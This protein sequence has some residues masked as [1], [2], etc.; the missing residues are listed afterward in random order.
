MKVLSPL[1]TRTGQIAIDAFICVIAL[2]LAYLLRLEGRVPPAAQ[3]QLMAVAPLI[4]V[5]RAAVHWASGI[6]RV[7]WRYVGIR[8]ALLFAR[9]VALVSIVLLAL[10]LFLPDHRGLWQV[11]ISII[12]LEGM[13]TFLGMAGTRVLRRIVHER[14][15]KPTT[16]RDSMV[17]TVLV[18]AGENALL[19]AK[20]AQRHPSLGI[21]VVGYVDDDP[22]KH[23]MEIHGPRVLGPIEDLRRVAGQTGARQVIITSNAIA[24]ARI[25]EINDTAREMRLDLRIVPGFFEV[26]DRG[27]QAEA[28]REVRIEDLLS[29]DPV[30][31][32]MTMEALVKVYGG[33]RI[34]VTGAGGSIGSELCRQLSLM[35]PGK[36]FLLERDENGLFEIHRELKPRLGSA[37]CIPVLADIT[38]GKHL[39][40]VF[41]ELQPE[42]VVHAAA[43]KHVPVMESF[44]AAAV[45]NNVFGTRTLAELADRSGCE[46]FLLISTDKA[47]NP[48]SVMGASKRLAEMVVQSIAR[49]SKT[50]FSCV[51]FGNVLGSRGSVVPIFREQIRNGGPVTVTHPEATRYFMTIPEASNLVL[52]AAT[53]GQQGEVFLLDMGRPVRIIDLARQ[54][55][56]LSGTTEE[57]VPIKIIGTRPGEKLYEE[58]NTDEETREPTDLRK[59]SRVKPQPIDPELLAMTLERLKF[60]VTSEDHGAVRDVLRGLEIGYAP[61]AVPATGEHPVVS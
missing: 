16:R 51:R 14:K 5:V 1:Q 26:I 12:F 39:E 2:G 20:E 6:Y 32:S 19:I 7:V 52:Q 40:R 29:R 34:L 9:S 55:I 44:P 47:I 49:T 4:V 3:D 54:L 61:P 23:G 17:P 58:L 8:E 45:R 59:I 24:A 13:L 25:L 53:L 15:S 57:R 36:L 10:R 33:K 50:R 27:G 38:D 28:L 48:T 37:V 42:V 46:S 30:P 43:F 11:P 31:P 60:L 56:Q 35:R 41:R 22:G 21:K 18:G